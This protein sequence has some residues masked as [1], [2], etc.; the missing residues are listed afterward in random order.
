MKIKRHKKCSVCRQKFD[1]TLTTQKVCSWQC[2]IKLVEIEKQEKE[3]IE[4]FRRKKEFRENDIKY[5]HKKAWEACSI[6]IRTRDKDLPCVSFGRYHDGQYHAGHYRP[7][8][9]NAALRYDERNI[10]KQCS[11]CNRF[12]GGNLTLYRES[13]ISRIGAD[14]VE[15]LDRNH[16]VKSWTIDELKEIVQYYKAKLKELKCSN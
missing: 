14:I 1:R 13:L 12:K 10:H 2:A 8:G 11:A 7:S 3:R 15:S 4:N 9:D 6:Y 5:W 16:E